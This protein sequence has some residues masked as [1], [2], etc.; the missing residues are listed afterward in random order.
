M[1]M[2]TGVNSSNVV[3]Y[4]CNGAII[5]S[6]LRVPCFGAEST[7]MDLSTGGP[8]TTPHLPR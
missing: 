7:V 2:I 3:T 5:F 4:L 1:K 6:L 8:Q